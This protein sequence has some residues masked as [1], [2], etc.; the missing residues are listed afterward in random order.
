MDG[1]ERLA[2]GIAH[3]LNNVLSGLVSYPELLLMELPPD[4]P[5]RDPVEVVLTS[6]KRATAIVSD[7]IMLAN[8]AANLCEPVDLASVI[9]H[10]LQGDGGLALRAT[11]PGID[12]VTSVAPDLPLVLAPRHHLRQA[13]SSLLANA[14]A[15]SPE[16]GTIA[17]TAERCT[18]AQAVAGWET[19]PAGDYVVLS[20]SDQ[21]SP[22]PA[23]QGSHFF[24]PY[25]AKSVL[26]R[27]VSGLGLAL[28]V[29]TVKS[30]DGRV[31]LRSDAD[32]TVVRFYLRRAEG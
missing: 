8:G 6:G 22:L 32:G 14:F 2:G 19:I 16:S 17:V 29:K 4:S 20:V 30:G 3:E 27:N 31:D 26:G 10:G 15:A 18:L 23:D 1:M 21:G 28:A 7:L 9:D 11:R 24:D 5:L 12:V 13:L 25:F